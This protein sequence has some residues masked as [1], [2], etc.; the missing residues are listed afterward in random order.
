MAENVA[1]T[2]LEI[3]GTDKVATTMKELREQIKD[4]RDELLSLT[5]VEEKTEKQKEREVVVIQNLQKATKLLSDVTNAHKQSQQEESKQIDIATASYKELQARLTYLRKAYKDMVATERESTFGEETLKEINEIDT[6]LKDIDATMGQHQRNVGNYEGAILSSYQKLRKEIKEYQG[7]VLAAEEGTEEW[8]EAM[9]KLAEAQFKMRDMNE[10]SRYSVADLG[11]QLTNLTG[12]ASGVMSGFS[13]LQGVTALLGKENENLQ[14]TMVKLQAGMAI[15]QGLKGMEGMIDKVKGMTTALQG[16]TAGMST[17]EKTMK[18]M[19]IGLII[20]LIGTLITNWEKVIAVFKRTDRAVEDTEAKML[21]A[22]QNMDG[23]IHS[24]V[25]NLVGEY[26][27]LREQ[28]QQLGSEAERQEWITNNAD[29]FDALGLAVTDLNSA[30]ETFVNNS[31]KVI[32]ALTLQAQASALASIYQQAYAEG[33]AK[34]QDLKKIRDSIGAGYDPS[35]QEASGA[36][37][38]SGDYETYTYTPTSTYGLTGTSATTVLPTVNAEGADKLRD[39]YDTEMENIDAEV[40]GIMNE[41][42]ATKAAA[43]KA[44][45][46][47]GMT[48]GKSS[49]PSSS[50]SKSGAKA[51]PVK[52]ME[53]LADVSM[54]VQNDIQAVID[55]SVQAEIEANTVYIGLMGERL[56]AYDEE[57]AARRKEEEERTEKEREEAR[58]RKEIAD[59]EAQ[60]K[61][62][63]YIDAAITTANATSSILGSIADMTEANADGSLRSARKTK[64]IRI[65]STIIDTLAGA[66]GALT[67]AASNPG[68]PPGFIIGTANA[69][70]ILATGMANVAKMRSTQITGNSGSSLG[71]NASA[72]VSAPSID[73]GLLAT[74]NVTAASEEDLLNR[75]A[76]PQKVYILQSDIEA[77]NNQSRVQ[78]QES[79]F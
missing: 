6:K 55:N 43:A 52:R 1:V 63:A 11:E 79:S 69:A 34:K 75:L 39:Y 5:Q 28:Y 9:R 49:K 62:E 40:D 77:A 74:H 10:K 47:A 78:V 45:A 23:E 51:D 8:E 54:R 20:G 66:T 29:A 25:A 18:G 21:S 72:G 56:E 68:G 53:A 30:Q 16:A 26:D 38:A 46:A 76:S 42:I 3:R 37:L 19:G 15:V 73:T 7:Q 13:A 32:K 58:K 17:L 57:T 59:K 65:A 36:G 2:T 50:G 22:A 64:N 4:Y 67:S 31:D 33:Y 12:I 70:A 35:K 61:K 41:L 71:G 24:S 14:E 27:L 48:G 44:S 60:A